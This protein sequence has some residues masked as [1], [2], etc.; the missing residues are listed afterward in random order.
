MGKSILS[1][2][3][4]IVIGVIVLF[5]N[6]L[7]SLV[8][9]RMTFDLTDDGLYTLSQ[10]SK[11]IINKL[12]EP[13]TL[14]IYISRTD[15]AK[16]PAVKIYGDRVQH[17]AR[18]YQRASGGKVKVE[19][20]DPRPD[21]EEE[22]WAQKYG[23]TP[24]SLPTGERLFFGLAAVSGAGREE[25]IPI[26][27]LN[28]QEYLEYDITRLLSTIAGGDK[29]SIG[30]LSSLKI[31]GTESPSQGM[32]GAQR[33]DSQD[34]WVLAN[35][36]ANL[37]DLKYLDNGVSEI[38]PSIR[39]LMVIHPKGLL[40]QTLYAIDQF[41]VKGGSLFVAI[42]PYCSADVPDGPPN[43]P[44]AVFAE[45]SSQLKELLAPWGIEM[46]EKKAVADLNLAA[47]VG[48]NPGEPPTDFLLW[49]SLSKGAGQGA[50]VINS[51]DMTTSKLENVLLP[52]AGALKITPIPG[53]SV[54]TL[55]Q[56]TSQ[57][58]LMDEGDYRYGGGQPSSLL[59]KF[60]PGNQAYPLAVR[61][62]GKFKSSF[63]EKP[64]GV[65][66]SLA[67]V[68]LLAEGTEIGRVV[69]VSDVDFLT[70]MASVRTQSIM[71]TKL[72][73][74]IND[75]QPFAANTME[76]LLGSSDLI[77]LRSRGQFSRPFTRVEE[78]EKHAAERWRHEEMTFQSTLN[79]ANSR[80]TELQEGMKPGS[81]QVFNKAL[82]DEVK[83]LR[84]ERQN[85]Q[86]RLREVRRNLR[87][88]KERLGKILFAL[89]TFLVPSILILS[90]LLSPKKKSR[91]ASSNQESKNQQPIV[92]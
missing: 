51:T 17:L 1:F 83:Q 78:I 10:G 44:T 65:Q 34:P 27:D 26:I 80:L 59:S 14:K 31:Q 4:I 46:V 40:P 72:V 60:I 67:D 68:P 3:N 66:G 91:K 71:G 77:S 6:S 56:T 85:A 87:Q 64:A 49:L 12:V 88:D 84:D 11:N 55:L 28:R 36:L 32:P 20:Y 39:T 35:Q 76:N 38:D 33:D 82:L 30:I 61:L 29:P 19:I 2:A 57:A 23:L 70:D 75:N 48:V 58:A 73:N 69:V 15:G 63:K 16:Y 47:K 54:E 74:L 45:R 24:L 25:A 89:N 62:T 50:P 43:S 41:V 53:V 9:G 42:D 5:L 13:V 21:S 7:S 81:E 18:E 37:G 52:W 90:V 92:A 22:S 86:E 79:Q 8:L